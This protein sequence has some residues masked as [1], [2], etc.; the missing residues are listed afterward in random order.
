MSKGGAKLCCPLLYLC[1]VYSVTTRSILLVKTEQTC[2]SWNSAKGDEEEGV[3]N[4][5]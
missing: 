2:W 5:L 3:M 1:T 4:E